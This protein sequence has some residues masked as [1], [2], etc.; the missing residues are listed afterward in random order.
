MVL[1]GGGMG[2]VGL[3]GLRKLEVDISKTISFRALIL[4]SEVQKDWDI[5]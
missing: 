4:S 5:S 1:P 2:A 3:M